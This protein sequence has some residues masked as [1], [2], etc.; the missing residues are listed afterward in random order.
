MRR[1][2]ISSENSFLQNAAGI[3]AAAI[4]IPLA[5]VVK[6]LVWPF[7][8]PLK[9]TADEVSDY[10]RSFLNDGGDEMDWDDFT[11]IPIADRRLDAIRVRAGEVQLPL[12]S[13]GGRTL[14]LLLAE[15][16]ALAEAERQLEG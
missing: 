8:K 12:T 15:A 1:A 9:R 13:E 11:C 5:V 2:L 14:R 16:D 4:V 6:L 3:V 10:L 7:E